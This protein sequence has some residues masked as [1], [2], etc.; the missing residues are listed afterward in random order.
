MNTI[1]TRFPR[2]NY[3]MNLETG[4]LLTRA[5]M[6]AEAAE[7]YDFDDWTNAVELWEYYDYTDIPVEDLP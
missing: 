5:Q 3:Y 6:Y 1:Y 7:L 4:E 2:K